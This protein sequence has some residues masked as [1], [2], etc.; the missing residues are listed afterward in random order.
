MRSHPS[1]QPP[2]LPPPPPTYSLEVVQGVDV[3]GRLAMAPAHPAPRAAKHVG[4]PGPPLASRSH[5]PAAQRLGA[6]GGSTHRGG[7][8]ETANHLS[9]PAHSPALTVS[10][11]QPSG[12]RALRPPS[13]GMLGNAV[14]PRGPNRQDSAN[15]LQG[16]ACIAQL[17]E[18]AE[19]EE[20]HA[21]PRPG[22][23][24]W[25]TCAQN[26]KRKLGKRGGYK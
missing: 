19:R 14:H 9:F 21:P 12:R 2:G 13:R 11:N 4:C 25:E 1:F 20:E 6:R 8:E 5:A 22:G 15:R 17:R 16:P 7:G 3:A 23:R 10:R 26:L 24:E 18:E